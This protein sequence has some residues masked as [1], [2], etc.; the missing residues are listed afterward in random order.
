MD[1]GLR[2]RQI[3]E[4]RD[5]EKGG[6]LAD[7]RDELSIAVRARGVHGQVVQFVEIGLAKRLRRGHFY[8][9]RGSGCLDATHGN[10]ITIREIAHRMHIGITRNQHFLHCA[11]CDNSPYFVG[12][13]CGF[14]PKVDQHVRA[15]LRNIDGTGKYGIHSIAA[16]HIGDV[17]HF[18]SRDSVRRR[19]LLE[20]M[21]VLHDLEGQVAQRLS[22]QYFYFGLI[23]L[24]SHPCSAHTCGQE[25]ESES[26]TR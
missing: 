8:P 7:R 6:D 10:A 15:I 17:G 23:G 12:R 2:Q 1:V 19:L 24:P 13:S 11:F 22:E 18:E 4:G 25:P 16:G 5:G 3:A 21:I 26:P 14:G 9:H 20:D